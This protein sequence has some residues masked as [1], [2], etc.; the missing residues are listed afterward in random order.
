MGLQQ[1]G[2]VAPSRD[3]DSDVSRQLRKGLDPVAM[4]NRI[5]L[6]RPCRAAGRDWI[7]SK[8]PF[9]RSRAVAAA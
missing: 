3:G 7:D 8:Q 5:E 6:G 9:G 1:Q 2:G 4:G